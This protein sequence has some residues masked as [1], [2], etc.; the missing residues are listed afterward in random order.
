MNARV[1]LFESMTDGG[2][3]LAPGEAES[4]N[5][6]ID[7]FRDEVL[8]ENGNAAAER[9]C[10]ALAVTFALQWT[11][12]APVGLRDGIEQILATMPTAAGKGTSDA[13][14]APAG[15]LTQ[16]TEITVYRAVYEHAPAPLGL[17][18]NQAAARAHC[19]AQARLLIPDDVEPTFDWI[20]DEDDLE[21]PW[22]LVV[23]FGGHG[24]PADFTVYPVTVAAAYDPEA[25][26]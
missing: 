1:E 20:G 25:D 3:R 26:A 22:E 2:W 10:L 19:E 6:I 14:Q 21:E 18:T 23:E 12:S 24:S 11:D 4:V 15:E 8:A 5:Q 9:D 13:D 7:A 16:P 17:Y